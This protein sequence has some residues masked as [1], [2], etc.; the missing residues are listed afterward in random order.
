MERNSAE[1]CQRVEQL[2]GSVTLAA[3]EHLGAEVP[4]YRRSP[5]FASARQ[6]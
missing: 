2:V 4:V 5:C 1:S 6:P 3:L